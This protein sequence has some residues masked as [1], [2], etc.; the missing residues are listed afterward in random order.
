LLPLPKAHKIIPENIS[1]WNHSKGRVDEMTHYLDGMTFPFPK[2]TPKQHLVICE[3]KKT[4]VNL[5]FIL[6]HYFPTK[7]PPPGKAYSALQSHH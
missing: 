1:R 6:K 2:G 3:F 5:C 7:R 4:A